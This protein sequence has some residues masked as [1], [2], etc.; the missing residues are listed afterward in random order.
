MNDKNQKIILPETHIITTSWTT[1]SKGPTEY[2]YKAYEFFNNYIKKYEKANIQF[3]I[4]EEEFFNIGNSGIP[5]K[6]ETV[7][8]SLEDKFKDF[9]TSKIQEKILFGKPKEIESK[10]L[11][12]MDGCLPSKGEFNVSK[13]IIILQNSETWWVRNIKFFN[14]ETIELW[15]DDSLDF[16]ITNLLVALQKYKPNIKTKLIPNYKEPTPN[17]ENYNIKKLTK[18]EYDIKFDKKRTFTYMVWCQKSYSDLHSRDLLDIDQR[19]QTDIIKEIKD[20]IEHTKNS[21]PKCFNKEPKLILV[22]WNPNYD[23]DELIYLNRHLDQKHAEDRRRAAIYAENLENYFGFEVEVY[24]ECDLPYEDL[25]KE[26]DGLI[27]TP[28]VK[29]WEVSSRLIHECINFRKYL[30][31]TKTMLEILPN[32]TGIKKQLNE[33]KSVG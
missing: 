28:S 6:N 2:H 18:E 16:P 20:I 25:L 33:I 13:V 17:F 7:K 15:Y 32:N 10:T 19:Y 31:L 21:S 27:Y 14:T 22:G 29:N 1:S 30:F 11:I 23:G 5:Y 24:P 9:N 8:K 12:F 3:L 26:F 4:S